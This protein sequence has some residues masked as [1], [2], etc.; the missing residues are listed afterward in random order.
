M[1]ATGA[2]RG[3]QDVFQNREQV[4]Y[5]DWLGD[6]PVHAAIERPLTVFL[7][8]VRGDGKDGK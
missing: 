8:R 3:Q 4:V 6:M 2:S 1:R 7:E 5:L